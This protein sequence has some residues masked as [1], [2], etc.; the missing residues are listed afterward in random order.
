M[1][2]LND[3]LS[4]WEIGFR[5]AGRDPTSWW[6]GIPLTVRDNFRMLMDAIL[7]G[8]LDC[9]TI[10]PEKRGDD[11][12][13]PHLFYIRDD[14]DAIYECINGVRFKRKLLKWAQIERWAFMDWC[15]GRGIPL[16]EFWFPP[17]WKLD[18]QWREERTTAPLPA[19][20]PA[21]LAAEPGDKPETETTVP[22]PEAAKGGGTPAENSTETVKQ[23]D[24]EK[25]DKGRASDLPRF[26]GPIVI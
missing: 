14:L 16:A 2:L 19:G 23:N 13:A 18:Y 25:E 22:E 17:G 8:H 4:V 1:A 3:D 12:E 11:S 20:T 26:F 6:P 10:S 5:W 9:I 21:G 24:G 7:S 15:E